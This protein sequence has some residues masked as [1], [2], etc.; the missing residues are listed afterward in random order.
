MVV[1]AEKRRTLGPGTPLMERMAD[2]FLCFML[3]PYPLF[4]GLEGYANLTEWKFLAYL[5]IGG[6]ILAASL[7]LRGELALVGAAPAQ[8]PWRAAEGLALGCWLFSALSALCSV[9]RLTAFWGGP[10]GRGW[11]R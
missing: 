5:V 9:D 10:G 2:A 11:R 6:G 7:L 3:G 8:R 4:T 1:R